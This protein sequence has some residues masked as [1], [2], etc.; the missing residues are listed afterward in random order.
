MVNG[1]DWRKDTEVFTAIC[2]ALGSIM[3]ANR[4]EIVIETLHKQCPGPPGEGLLVAALALF[5]GRE[6][7]LDAFAE[8]ALT[9]S[10]AV[11]DRHF[12]P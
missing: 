1:K 10:L 9:G 11:L 8:S 4:P 12:T 2:M 6:L 7:E 5:Q 3:L